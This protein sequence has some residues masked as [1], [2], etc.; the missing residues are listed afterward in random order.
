MGGTAGPG[1]HQGAIRTPLRGRP[2]RVRTSVAGSSAR[3]RHNSPG[4]DTSRP[5]IVESVGGP[6]IRCSRTTRR[7]PSRLGA[8]RDESRSGLDRGPSK[9]ARRRPHPRERGAVPG[10][11]GASR[12]GRAAIQRNSWERGGVPRMARGAEMARKP[13]WPP[14]HRPIPRGFHA[15]LVD[16]LATRLGSWAIAGPWSD[17][18]ARAVSVHLEEHL[19]DSPRRGSSPRCTGRIGCDDWSCRGYLRR[20]QSSR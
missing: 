5:R 14:D 8:T 7:L 17:K 6:P 16:R 18:R 13:P 20:Q 12:T 15:D 10:E 19:S 1:D 3:A 11:A 2:R 9:A 4:K